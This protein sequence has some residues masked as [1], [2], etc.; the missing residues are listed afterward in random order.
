MKAMVKRPTA[1]LDEGKSFTCIIRLVSSPLRVGLLCAS[2]SA[3]PILARRREYISVHSRAVQF[4]IKALLTSLYSF[5][6]RTSFECVPFAL[7]GPVVQRQALARGVLPVRQVPRVA[8]GQAVRL[9]AR[10]DL[11]RQLLRRAVRQPLRRLRRGLP[12]R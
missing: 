9:Q 6:K 7:A 4:K 11:L 12:R 3:S 1:R 8:G 5:K 2:Q 10:Q